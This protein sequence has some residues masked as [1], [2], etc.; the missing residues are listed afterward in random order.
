[1][2]ERLVWLIQK[3]LIENSKEVSVPNYLKHLFLYSYLF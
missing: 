1:M 3:L 2:N